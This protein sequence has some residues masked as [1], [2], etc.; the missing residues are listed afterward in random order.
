M[1]FSF[2]FSNAQIPDST[3]PISQDLH[4]CDVQLD[5]WE[6]RNKALIEKSERRNQGMSQSYSSCLK[7]ISPRT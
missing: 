7:E 2:C 6:F 1:Q 3:R 4:G 5:P